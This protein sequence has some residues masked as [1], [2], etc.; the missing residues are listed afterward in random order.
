[1]PATVTRLPYRDR[2]HHR[3]DVSLTGTVQM[4]VRSC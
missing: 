4:L 3:C 1:M 2:R